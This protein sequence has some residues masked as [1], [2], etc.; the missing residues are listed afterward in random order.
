MTHDDIFKE[1][2]RIGVNRYEGM[3]LLADSGVISD[4]CIT[5]QD[6]AVADIENAV[7][8]LKGYRSK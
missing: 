8:W 1:F 4:N 7:D 2:D 5:V 3:M 6:I